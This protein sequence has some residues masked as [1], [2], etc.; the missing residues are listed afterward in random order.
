MNPEI[1]ESKEMY[2]EA[3]VAFQD[4]EVLN[5]KSREALEE[6]LKQEEIG[7][8]KAVEVLNER[9]QVNVQDETQ[10]Q[11]FIYEAQWNAWLA[12]NVMTRLGLDSL[13]TMDEANFVD[14]LNM[15]VQ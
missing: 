5:G 2:D 8:V 4:T 9:L 6:I 14:T 10:L 12:S 7:A 15:G 13:E 11:A 3:K 1:L